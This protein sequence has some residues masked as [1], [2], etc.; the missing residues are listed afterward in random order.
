[1]KNNQRI[2]I[3]LFTF[4]IVVAL[5]S[6]V[7]LSSKGSVFDRTRDS[8]GAETAVMSE[9]IVPDDASTA[10]SLEEVAEEPVE[11][12]V[13]EPVVEEPVVEEPVVEEP[14]IEEPVEEIAEEEPVE[15]VVEEDTNIKYYTCKINT[16]VTSL[17]MREQPNQNS[18]IIKNLTKNS[19]GYVIKPGNGWCKIVVESGET[20]YCATQYLAFTKVKKEDFP[21]E[22]ADMVEA[23]DDELGEAF[24]N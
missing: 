2:F 20:G 12:V 10:E 11:E 5:G 18:K 9:T 16:K 22:Y 19:N 3:F 4:F 21:A 8:V 14:V 17:R 15:E 7:F 13:E 6:L 24:G 1:M 23:P